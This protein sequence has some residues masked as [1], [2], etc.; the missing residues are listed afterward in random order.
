MEFRLFGGWALL[1]SAG[2]SLLSATWD[3]L[4][5]GSPTP[6]IRGITLLGSLLFIIGLPA[7]QLRQPQIGRLGQL[8]LLLL[9]IGAIMAFLINV[10][11]L[12]GGTGV[13]DALPFTSALVG[14]LG[15]LIVGWRTS[16]ARVVSVW[17]GWLLIAGSVLNFA[18]G[19]AGVQPLADMFG[20][21]GA[22]VG[23]A[24]IA[25]YGWNIVHPHVGTMA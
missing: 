22:L 16:R 13:N 12:A 7:I 10:F 23:A 14:L 6:L 25:G 1:V 9:G 18:S 20:F 19:F 8:G 4:F 11:F 24:A 17:I 5:S 21:M 2:I 15:A 3:D